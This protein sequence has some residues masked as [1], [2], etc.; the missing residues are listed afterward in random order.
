MR[1]PRPLGMF[2]VVA[3]CLTADARL[4]AAQTATD[5]TALA[6]S[7][8]AAQ[9]AARSIRLAWDHTPGP[10]S[11]TVS[12]TVGARPDKVMGTVAAPSV[13]AKDAAA[14]PIRLFSTVL[15]NEPDTPHRCSLRWGRDPKSGLPMRAAFNEVV[16]LVATAATS[17]APASVTARASGPGEITLTWNAVPGATA[18]TIGRSVE[19][20]GYRMRCDLCSTSTTFVDRYA[21]TGSAHS[22]TVSAVTAA[23]G[24]ARGTSNKV[25]ALGTASAVAAQAGAGVNPNLRAPA[26][27]RAAVSGATTALVTWGSVPGAPAYQVLRSLNGGSLT[28]VARVQAGT[29]D[30]VEYPDYLGGARALAHSTR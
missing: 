17:N 15:V 2:A 27:V 5:S 10:T 18:Y 14:P 11:Y 1:H 26:S 4:A 20:D 25:V 8:W 19:P 9:T 22:Y 24:T 23:G 13:A 6:A 12:C 21:R 30:P 16:P 29:S 28:L 7:M 3:I